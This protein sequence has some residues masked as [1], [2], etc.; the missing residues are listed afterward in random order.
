M[1]YVKQNFD[2]GMILEHTHLIKMEE[3]I[4]EASKTGKKTINK[5]VNFVGMSIWWYDNQTLAP[6]GFCGGVTARG[7][8]T[9]L[10]EYFSFSGVKNYC[11]S[12]CSLGG[13]SSSDASSIAIKMAPKWTGTDGDIWTLD[14]ITNDFKRNI[15]IGTIDDYL[16]GTGAT[17]FYGALRVFKNRV[18]ALSGTNAIV[19]CSNALKRNNSNYTS[20]SKNT[21]GHALLDY[22]YAMMNVAARNNWY[23]VDQYRCGITDETIALTTLDGLHLNNF[24][25]TLAVKPWIEQ[26]N[27]IANHL[28]STASSNSSSTFIS[29]YIDIDG[30]FVEGNGNWSHTNY[31]EVSE[32]QTWKYTGDTSLVEGT[33]SAVYGYNESMAPIQKLLGNVDGTTGIE[34]TI[35]SG[36]NFIAACSYTVDTTFTIEKV[37]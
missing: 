13:T 25:Y 3:G 12:G 15:P 14:T 19:I 33:V 16:N 10:Q 24:G 5:T 26:F 22:E 18:E 6:S 8:Q 30:A 1:S 11:Y 32:G 27:I 2:R 23:F 35:P 36:I 17:T 20:T 31:I 29:G 37:S 4:I 7:Y 34:F 28:N 9:L 21:A